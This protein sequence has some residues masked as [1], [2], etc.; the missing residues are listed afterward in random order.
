MPPAA[1]TETAT[2]PVPAG[3]F[4]VSWVELTTVTEV[5]GV[6]P[7]STVAVAVKLDPV[8][9]TVVPPPSGPWSGLTLVTVGAAT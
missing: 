2:V 4:T 3:S 5:P 6:V 8:T 9:V 1:V 7:K